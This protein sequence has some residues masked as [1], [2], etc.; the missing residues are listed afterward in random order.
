MQT[1]RK[2]FEDLLTAGS[3]GL[4]LIWV[5]VAFAGGVTWATGLLG[6]AAITLA[7]QYL[8]VA[9]GLALERFWVLSGSLFAVSGVWLLLSA[10]VGLGPVV[11]VALGAVVLF[12]T[13]L[14]NS[15]GRD[16]WTQ[17]SGETRAPE[18]N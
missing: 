5:G 15:Y 9:V 3:W 10:G 1:T 17:R 8:R 13:L 12:G 7:T 18:S 6:V 11:L 14:G 2:A 16:H 4:F